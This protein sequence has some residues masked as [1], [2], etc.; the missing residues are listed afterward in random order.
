MMKE[1][2][3]RKE[4]WQHNAIETLYFGGG[5]PSVLG[6]EA[7]EAF[8]SEVKDNAVLSND[9]EITVE[10]NP[11]DMSKDFLSG[12]KNIGVNRLSVGIQSFDDAHLKMMNRNH[13]GSQA[14]QAL[15]KAIDIGFH[16]ITAD[17]IY[18]IPEQTVEAFLA[19]VEM[20]TDFGIPHLS[21]Y[22][23]T[24]EPKT[25]MDHWIKTGKMNAPDDAHQEEAFFALK[26][27]LQTQGFVHYEIS[28]FAKTGFESKHNSNYWT[29]KAYVGVGPSA[30][31]FDGNLQR[32][33][34]VANNALY[35]KAIENNHPYY[36]TEELSQ[37]EKFNEFIMLGLRLL[38]GYNES[39]LYQNFSN[40]VIQHY[41]TVRNALLSEGRLEKNG[42]NYRLPETFRFQADGIAS[43]FFMV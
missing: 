23:L 35:V 3:L 36:E 26:D 37:K 27:F 41:D 11:E 39:I 9:I 32:R 1:L 5:T 33:W 43:E 28:N 22:A 19:D 38:N 10:C 29:G 31:S 6:V 34:N 17:V 16:N 40:E 13:S 14:K 30:H 21:A 25:V 15:E 18:G 42:E 2:S 20:L 7:L 4:E 8:I 24:Q 12:L